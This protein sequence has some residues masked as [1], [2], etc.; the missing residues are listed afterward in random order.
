MGSHE[1]AN[2]RL[3]AWRIRAAIYTL[4]WRIAH[5]RPALSI[6]L[7][8]GIADRSRRL[9][10]GIGG[11][12]GYRWRRQVWDPGLGPR[13]GNQAAGLELLKILTLRHFNIRVH[14]ETLFNI[15]G[16]CVGTSYVEFSLG[17]FNIIGCKK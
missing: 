11:R 2:I 10:P 5:R 12:Y 6:E 8:S 15:W 17:I 14:F 16:C 13:T 1:S 9:E 3:S 7:F 4:Y